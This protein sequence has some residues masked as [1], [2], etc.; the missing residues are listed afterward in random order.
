MR[1]TW[2]CHSKPQNKKVALSGM[3]RAR[4]VAGP[5][6]YVFLGDRQVTGD[7]QEQTTRLKRH[8]LISLLPQ[9]DYC[10]HH[11]EQNDIVAGVDKPQ[12]QTAL[13]E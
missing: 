1:V 11:G 9:A 5:F 4:L 6:F 3:Q 12:L 7:R 2:I 8:F 10:A 13:L